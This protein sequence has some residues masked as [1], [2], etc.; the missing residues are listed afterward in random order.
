MDS[1]SYALILL[2]FLVVTPPTS[3]LSAQEVSISPELS[4]RNYFAYELLGEIGDRYLIFRD[5]GFIK[6]VDVFNEYME[7]SQHAELVLEKKRTDMISAV[8]LDTVFQL[9]Y[10]YIEKD[11]M[12]MKMRRYN[13]GVS[14]VDSSTLARIPKKNITR[15]INSVLSENKSKVL[16]YSLNKDD[17]LDVYLYDNKQNRLAAHQ[18][19]IF[20][21]SLNLKKRLRDIQL[22]D[23]GKLL[24]LLHNADQSAYDKADKL[25][26]LYFDLGASANALIEL[27]LG[28]KYRK[29]AYMDFDNVND[30]LI[31][32]GLYSE[33]RAKESKGIYL[34]S[35]SLKELTY[36]EEVSF[37]PYS[38]DLVDEV[39]RTKK[40]K[41]RIFENFVVKEVIKRQDGGILMML[42]LAKEFS[43]R[44]SYSAGYDRSASSYNR[45]GWVDYY[46]EDIIIASITPEAEIAWTKILYKKQFSQ[47]DEAIYSSFFVM[48]T[49]SR[50]RLLYNDE[51]KKS[52]TVSEYILDPIGKVARNSLLSTEDQDMKLRFRDAIQISN[53]E[54]LVPSENNFELTLVKISY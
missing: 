35:K 27:D 7:L 46:N 6:E 37:V 45:K 25:E 36:K 16:M 30:K 42:E 5:K 26:V 24:M 4:I 41:S 40:K 21:K 43:R 3:S 32:C 23:S 49:P 54:V 13:Q 28:D 22:T 33:R 38:N 53:K 31:I 9:I 15:R 34:L 14:L 8:G 20:Q 48:K 18:L 17:N 11:T 2:F 50:M 44:S 47:D 10:G 19:L 39:S 29:D 51:I 12:I 1:L 52:N